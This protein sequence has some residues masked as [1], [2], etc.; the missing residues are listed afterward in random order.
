[1]IHL[2]VIQCKHLVESRTVKVD[3][4]RELTNSLL[5]VVELT[6]SGGK[7]GLGG[8]KLDLGRSEFLFESGNL[9]GGILDLSNRASSLSG[10]LL[11]RRDSEDH[12]LEAVVD[13]V[14][15]VVEETLSTGDVVLDSLVSGDFIVEDLESALGLLEGLVEPL[16]LVLL[17]GDD[18]SGVLSVHL[19]V[20][21][22][23]ANGVLLIFHHSSVLGNEVGHLINLISS[24][25]S[26]DGRGR[27]ASV[28]WTS[29]DGS[30]ARVL[31][32]VALVIVDAA[33]ATAHLLVLLA[34]DLALD[35]TVVACLGAVITGNRCVLAVV[36]SD[37]DERV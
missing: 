18:L 7:L 37:H 21:L 16:V 33:A 2:P 32:P 6:A 34:R 1:M 4:S 35:N 27:W 5:H 13:P 3:A 26:G 9:L 31:L 19:G 15:L 23:S 22:Q 11:G 30:V 29:D 24:G 10:G 8:D 12:V 17:R 36:D 14:S 25:S 20:G 28:G